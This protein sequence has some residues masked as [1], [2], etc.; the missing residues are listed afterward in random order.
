MVGQSSPLALERAKSDPSGAQF[1][2]NETFRCEVVGTPHV[3]EAF[4]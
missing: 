2:P 3:P 1:N 4:L